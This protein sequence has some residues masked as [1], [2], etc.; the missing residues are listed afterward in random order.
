MASNSS[1]KQCASCGK[2][3]RLHCG[4]CDSHFYCTHDC[5]V[6]D[7]NSHKINCKG[8][9]SSSVPPPPTTQSQGVV[10]GIHFDT[11]SSEMTFQWFRYDRIT[12]GYL[13]FDLGS[14]LATN[15]ED[16]I[17][18]YE[19]PA[20]F[21]IAHDIT[22]HLDLGYTI[23]LLTR[24]GF[25][26]TQDAVPN[27]SIQGLSKMIRGQDAASNMTIPGLPKTPARIKDWH[28]PAMAIGI[29]EFTSDGHPKEGCDLDIASARHLLDFFNHITTP[30]PMIDCVRINCAGD[31]DAGRPKFEPIKLPAN[32]AVFLRAP[33]PIS[34]GIELPLTVARIPGNIAMV[35]PR[36]ESRPYANTAVGFMHT[37]CDPNKTGGGDFFEGEASFGWVPLTWD[38]PV[39]SCI[40]ARLDKKALLP[41][42]AAA[43]A[44]FCEVHLQ[45]LIQELKESETLEE[46]C[47]G[48]AL[49]KAHVLDEI[50]K[51][52]FEKYYQAWVARQENPEARSRS[53]YEG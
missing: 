34:S 43:L 44:E 41:D 18:G 49:P 50:T 10:K 13:D 38:S 36:G 53:P 48:Q 31:V 8:G 9:Q 29:K 26:P 6:K 42:C 47:Y 24:D 11:T 15:D 5:Q 3:A 16:A 21:D 2:E 39:G 27:M 14:A 35:S 20:W 19:A 33:F 30:P 28:G 7:W 22:F 51:P 17:M 12:P 52:K 45:S 1:V 23:R 25:L 40:M 4:V 37:C 32:H 46:M